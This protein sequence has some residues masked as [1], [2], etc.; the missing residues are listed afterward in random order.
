MNVVFD[1]NTD[2]ILYQSSTNH[3]P[4]LT[5]NLDPDDLS[6]GDWMRLD[7]Q[8]RFWPC[9]YHASFFRGISKQTI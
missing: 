5:L 4:A 8:G 6:N 3:A 9:S 1:P 2:Q 7:I